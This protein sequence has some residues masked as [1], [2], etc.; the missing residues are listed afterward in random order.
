MIAWAIIWIL[1]ACLTMLFA[2]I[3][4]ING[5]LE[6]RFWLCVIFVLILIII[7]AFTIQEYQLSLIFYDN[8]TTFYNR[9]SNQNL[10]PDQEYMILGEAMNYNHYLYIYQLKFKT[11]GIFAPTYTKIKDLKPVELNNF[12]MNKYKWWE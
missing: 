11:W 1:L 5:S 7:P 10:T 3:E 12:D 6:W 8:Y 2:A 4:L 9:V